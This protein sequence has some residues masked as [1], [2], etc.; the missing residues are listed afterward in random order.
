MNGT[1]A[2]FSACLPAC[3]PA[4]LRTFEEEPPGLLVRRDALKERESVADSV[5]GVRGEIRR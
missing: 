2:F 4:C 5:G 3:L 1:G